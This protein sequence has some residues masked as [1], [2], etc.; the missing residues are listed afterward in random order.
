M[1]LEIFGFGLS[2]C[3]QSGTFRNLGKCLEKLW[4]LAVSIGCIIESLISIYVIFDLFECIDFRT[5]D[6]SASVHF[7]KNECGKNE[8]KIIVIALSINLFCLVVG[9]GFLIYAIRHRRVN[10]TLDFTVFKTDDELAA[11]I[12][13][14]NEKISAQ[15]REQQRAQQQQQEQEQQ[16]QQRE[17]RQHRQHKQHK[18]HRKH[19]KHRKHGKQ[20]QAR[21]QGMIIFIKTLTGKTISLNVDRNESIASVKQKFQNKEGIPPERQ[22]LIFAGKQLEDHRVLSD[23]NIQANSTL[24]MILKLREDPGAGLR[25]THGG[26]QK[27]GEQIPNDF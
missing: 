11:Q 15:Q 17:E 8:F 14:L 9:F 6:T 4:C 22:R 3:R 25:H 1:I 16:R 21:K 10:I 18:R 20:K 12:R 2:V 19:K 23:Y 13:D 24:H 5:T 27:S 7:D 26:I